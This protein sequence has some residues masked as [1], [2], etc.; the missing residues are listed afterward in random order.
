M[1]FDGIHMT[2]AHPEGRHLL[3]S[4]IHRSDRRVS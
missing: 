1:Q 4:D 2:E 3:A